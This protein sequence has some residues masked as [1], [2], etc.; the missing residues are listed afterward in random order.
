MSSENASSAVTYMSLSSDSDRP[1]WGTRLMNASEL[2]E[3]DPYKEIE[4]RSYAADASP[5]ALSPGYIAESD[6]EEDPEE[7]PIDYPTDR[8]DDDNDDESSDDDEDDDDDVKEDEDEEEVIAISNLPPSPLT[9]YSSP[10]PQI[11]P[12]PLHA[13]PT[14]PLGYRVVMIRLRAESPFTSHPLPL[15]SPIILSHTKAF[16]AMTRAAA[17]STYILAPRSETPP[18]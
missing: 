1:S 6:S 5:S 15:A 12:P 11:P 7:D 8:G 17:P 18:S 2:L 16:M 13:S 3:M 9:L 14:H 10:L 4:D